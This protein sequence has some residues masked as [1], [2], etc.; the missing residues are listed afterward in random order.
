VNLFDL[1]LEPAIVLNNTIGASNLKL[2]FFS[3]LFASL[4]TVSPLLNP[5]NLSS[6]TAHRHHYIDTLKN[7]IITLFY[8]PEVTNAS[9]TKNEI[10]YNLEESAE[11]S[12]ALRFNNPIFKYDYKLGNYLTKELISSFPNLLVSQTHVTGGIKKSSWYYSFQFLE[13]LNENIQNYTNMYTTQTNTPVLAEAELAH[14]GSMSGF[15]TLFHDLNLT[16]DFINSHWILN[17]SLNQK[18]YRIFLTS[19]MQ[20][21]VYAN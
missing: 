5:Y 2:N 3:D 18:F 6:I 14:P 9:L 7:K 11:S 20:Q 10:I 21:R 13:L 16:S 8:I 15:Y 12:R 17:N 4:I 19:S 1:K